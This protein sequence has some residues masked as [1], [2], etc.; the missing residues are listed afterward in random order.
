MILMNHILGSIEDYLYV[1]EEMM[2]P[3]NHRCSVHDDMVLREL[4]LT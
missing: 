1:M 2:S 4:L 3:R